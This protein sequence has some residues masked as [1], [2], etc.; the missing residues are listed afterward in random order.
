MANKSQAVRYWLKSG[1]ALTYRQM[2]RRTYEQMDTQRDALK[3]RWIYR[4]MDR[5]INGQ[6]EKWTYRQIDRQAD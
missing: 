5:H 1:P 2:D 6:T 3:E 4:Q